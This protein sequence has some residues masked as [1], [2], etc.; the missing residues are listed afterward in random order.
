MLREL[1]GKKNGRKVDQSMSLREVLKQIKF[2]SEKITEGAQIHPYSDLITYRVL[3]A[4]LGELARVDQRINVERYELTKTG[5]IKFSHL[6]GS[7][8]D[9]FW[10]TA[11]AT[12]S[13]NSGPKPSPI[14]AK[15][16]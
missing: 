11:L 13:Y 10:A 6:E 15:T 9:R 12:Y 8:D 16:F 3:I 2:E 4:R 7:H 14:L 5:R 1:S